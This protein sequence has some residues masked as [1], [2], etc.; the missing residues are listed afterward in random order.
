MVAGLGEK[1]VITEENGGMRAYPLFPFEP[2]RKC[3]CMKSN[4]Y[5]LGRIFP[6]N[7]TMLQEKPVQL[8]M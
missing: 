7:T 5:G 2:G 8:I 1:D 6:T 4:P 3:Y